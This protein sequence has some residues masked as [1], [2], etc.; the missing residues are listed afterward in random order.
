M[1]IWSYLR[2]FM[3]TKFIIVVDDD[4]DA[5]SWQDVL[6]AI[7]TNVDPSRDCT[8]ID[9]TPID[10]LDFASPESGLGSKIGMDATT[11]IPPETNRQ[12]GKKIHM[13]EDIIEKVTCNWQEYNLPGSGNPVWKRKTRND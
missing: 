2:Q 5:R 7:S 6:W 8:I 4:I 9:N 10:Y 1:A 3:Y 12:W 13:V 11:K